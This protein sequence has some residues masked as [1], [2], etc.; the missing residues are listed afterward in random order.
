MG[1]TGMVNGLVTYKK[2]VV[3]FAFCQTWCKVPQ[4]EI[5]SIVYPPE[6]LRFPGETD[7]YPPPDR[8]DVLMRKITLLV[9]LIVCVSMF[10]LGCTVSSPTEWCRRGSVWPFKQ[11]TQEMPVYPYMGSTSFCPPPCDPCAT[12]DPC[13]DM[14]GQG[15]IMPNAGNPY[16]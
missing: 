4:T 7:P 12:I 11:S 9:C 14:G 2:S 15:F 13:A 10:S 8:E 6:Y 3:L 1:G 5:W 16:P